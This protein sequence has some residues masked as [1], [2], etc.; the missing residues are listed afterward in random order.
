[1]KTFDD[2]KMLSIY[3][4]CIIKE[5]NIEQS[6]YE[7][8]IITTTDQSTRLTLVETALENMNKNKFYELIDDISKISKEFIKPEFRWN[9]TEDPNIFTTNNKYNFKKTVFKTDIA[10]L[11]RGINDVHFKLEDRGISPDPNKYTKYELVSTKYSPKPTSYNIQLS[12]NDDLNPLFSPVLDEDTIKEYE[13]YKPNSTFLPIN[14][15]II[16]NIVTGAR[17]L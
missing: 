2:L 4:R 1:M 12:F 6:S 16:A 10:K 11:E 17:A 7:N 14:I 3:N 15:P 8:P 5:N 9:P 13:G